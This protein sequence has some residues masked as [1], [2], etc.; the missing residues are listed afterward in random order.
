MSSLGPWSPVI[1]AGSSNGGRRAPRFESG[2]RTQAYIARPINQ[3]P[4]MISILIPTLNEKRNIADCIASVAWSDDV[5]VVDSGSRDG[6]CE[7][8][9]AAGGRVVDFK[10]NQQ[11]PKKKNWTLDNVV[12]KHDWLLILDADERILPELAEEI[13]AELQN[14]RADGYFINRR[15]IFLDQWIK[16]CGYYP[17]WNL[18]LFRHRLGRYERLHSADTSSGDNEVHEHLE[19]QGKTA[20]LKHDMLHYAYPDIAT[21]VE[22]HNRYSSWEAH[23]EVEG[24]LA[25]G[26][27]GQIGLHLSRRR[28]LR[29]WSRRM[30]FRPTLRFLYSYVLKLGFLDGRA[31]YMFCRLIATYEMLNVYKA[32]ELRLRRKAAGSR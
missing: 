29:E 31:G 23:V 32:Y 7:I 2:A 30:P 11:F 16:H 25:H 19:L 28:R 5:V 4:I 18:R 26:A 21:W 12:W 3:A 15:F 9:R 6:T 22:K 24:A 1:P 14:P 17:S 13:R 8:A 27:A 10:W 20:Y